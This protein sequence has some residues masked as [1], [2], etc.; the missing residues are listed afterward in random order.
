[1]SII[2]LLLV[3]LIGLISV[4]SNLHYSEDININNSTNIRLKHISLV[5]SIVTLLISL[6]IFTLFHFSSN[7]FQFVQNASIANTYNISFGVDGTSIYFVLLTTVIMP[8]ALLCLHCL[9]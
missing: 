6:F 8:I 2:I 5:T 1:M 7:H 9:Y 4:C 3:P